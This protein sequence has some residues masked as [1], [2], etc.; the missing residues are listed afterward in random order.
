MPTRRL[1]DH[2]SL[3]S[4][5]KQ[6]KGLRREF[7]SG[8][9][10]ARALVAECDPLAGDELSLAG[11]QL[12]IA[13]SYGFAS[14][15]RLHE[16]VRLRQHYARFPEPLTEVPSSP[17]PDDLLRLACLNYTQDSE[18]SVVRARD[19]LAE[20]PELATATV[21]TMAATGAVDE[22]TALLTEDPAAARRTG[23]PYDWEPLG[24]LCHSR[25]GDLGVGR[26]ALRTARALL[27][28]GAD[29]NTGF[30]W[31][32]LPSPFTA[33]TAALGGGEQGQPPHADALALARLLLDAG[34]DPND[35]QAL[36]NRMFSPA[37]D[38]LELL[39]EYGL[40]TDR[41]SPWRER[42][43]TAYPS[44]TQMVQ[45]QLRWA[46][47]HDM[48]ARIRLLLRHGVDPDGLGY[49]PNFGNRTPYELA[50]L[51]GNRECAGL[52][53]DAGAR[54]AGVDT[55]AGSAALRRDEG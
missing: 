34:A 55:A 7:R 9:A 21:H 5:R 40:G 41:P 42:L 26:S 32:G 43:G 44:P 27:A 24:H 51:A 37:N 28:A 22:I 49:H 12:V 6:A 54:T 16:H 39:F 8:S 36:Y 30:L 14:W 45:E 53:A 11:A 47:R 52:L 18:T 17:G 33:L 10:E 23:G 38:H 31:Q 13:R 46:A 35:N 19:L 20:T 29:P 15:P 25:I 2:P 3:E 4:L 50:V 1:P 48:P